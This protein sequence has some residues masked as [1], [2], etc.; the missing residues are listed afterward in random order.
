MKTANRMK[1][2][3]ITSLLQRINTL[4]K[5]FKGRRFTIVQN[6]LDLVKDYAKKE[7]LKPK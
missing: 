4:K 2:K 5:L 7:K 6:V 1:S 3:D